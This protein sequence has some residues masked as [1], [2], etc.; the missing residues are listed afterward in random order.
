[1][2]KERFPAVFEILTK[3]T[4]MDDISHGCT[5]KT[6]AEK[7]MNDIQ[8]VIANAGFKLKMWCISGEVP[9]EKASSDGINTSFAGYL[10]APLQ[11]Q[12]S[13]GLTEINY[14]KRNRGVK[15]DNDV[16]VETVELYDIIGIVEIIKAKLKIDMKEIVKYN[17]DEVLPDN[18]QQLWVSNIALIHRAREIKVQRSFVPNN[19]VWYVAV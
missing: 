8:E 15:K 5:E 18:L 17:Y 13:I 1:M 9:C 14:N 2:F 6:N 7:V 4:Y 16:P 19:A 3:F 12:M 11:D 10:W